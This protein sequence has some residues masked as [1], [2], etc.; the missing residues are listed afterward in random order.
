MPAG[1][2]VEPVAAIFALRVGKPLLFLALGTFTIHFS[3]ADII[4]KNE[5]A[6]YTNLGITAVI[7]FLTARRRADKDRV[8]GITPVLAARHLFTNGTLFHQNTSR[9]FISL[10]QQKH[11]PEEAESSAGRLHMTRELKR[12]R[13]GLQGPAL[14]IGYRGEELSDLEKCYGAGLTDSTGAVRLPFESIA[15]NL[16]NVVINLLIAAEVIEGLLVEGGMD[17]LNGVGE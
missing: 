7:D 1:R 11:K 2:A 6:F 16:A 14:Y 9:S 12:T 13:P 10:L 5:V 3:A 17:L 15:A 4:F 8:T